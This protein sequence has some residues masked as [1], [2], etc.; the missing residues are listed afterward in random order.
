MK[1]GRDTRAPALRKLAELSRDRRED[2][3]AGL[4]AAAASLGAHPAV[5]VVGGMPLAL[6][7]A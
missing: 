5:L 3:V 6:L 4:L 1:K 2:V 7:P